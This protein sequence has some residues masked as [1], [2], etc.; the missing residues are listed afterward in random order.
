MKRQD[1]TRQVMVKVVLREGEAEWLLSGGMVEGSEALCGKG[2]RIGFPAIYGS[3]LDAC[4]PPKN[5]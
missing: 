3:F 1:M 5:T 2:R 4:E